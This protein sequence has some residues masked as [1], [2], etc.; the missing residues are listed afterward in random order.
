MIT[1]V[2]YQM[3]NLGSIANMIAK[4]GGKARATSDPEVLRTADKLVLPGVGHFDRGMKNLAD[5]GLLP[6][7]RE[8]VVERR[9]PVLGI[10]LGM[11][12]MCRS[13]E[14]G[15]L[16]GLG[17]V[18]AEVRHFD[19]ATHPGIKIPHMGWNVARPVRESALLAHEPADPLRFY[20]VHSY[21]VDCAVPSDVLATSRHGAEFCAA[22]QRDNMWG[23]QF[24]PEKSH[25]FGMAL[26]R[27]FLAL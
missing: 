19:A 14:E 16:P 22:F 10:C 27:G 2:D 8:L 23:V 3:G 20:F 9:V 11:Q 17:W 7:L 13:S 25:A 18:D 15:E 26:F 6:V 1:V 4:V 12:L 5:L 24:H 21:F